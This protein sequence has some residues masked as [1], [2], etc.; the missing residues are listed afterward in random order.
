MALSKKY[1]FYTLPG[2]TSETLSGDFSTLLGLSGEA[3]LTTPTLTATGSSDFLIAD[4]A[5]PSPVYLRSSA[6][7]GAFTTLIG[8]GASTF[9]GGVGNDFFKITSPGDMLVGGVLGG[10]DTISSSYGSIDLT[11]LGAS[12]FG[13]EV[14]MV[15]NAEIGR[16]SCR[17]RVSSPV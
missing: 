10:S 14:T 1:T 7:K 6:K 11:T 17:E 3:T 4:S 5:N 2:N 12:T 9:V 15:G 8:N 13:N 16:A